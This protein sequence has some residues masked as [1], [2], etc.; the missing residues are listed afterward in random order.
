MTHLTYGSFLLHSPSSPPCGSPTTLSPA[1]VPSTQLLAVSIFT[2]PSKIPWGQGHLASLSLGSMCLLS[3]S[4]IFGATKSLGLY[5]PLQYIPKDQISREGREGR[6]GVFQEPGTGSSE[7]QPEIIMSHDHLRVVIIAFGR[8]NKPSKQGAQGIF[9]Q[10]QVS[11]T[12][13]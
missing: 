13:I 8:D 7:F 1:Y 6:R 4:L 2:H 11:K 12:A 10:C 3:L 5:F 9:R